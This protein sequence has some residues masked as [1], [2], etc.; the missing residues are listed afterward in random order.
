M[1]LNNVFTHGQLYVKLS[2]VSSYNNIIIAFNSPNTRNVV[3][4][5]IF[6]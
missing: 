6:E 2:R 4:N 3:F 5:E 1:L